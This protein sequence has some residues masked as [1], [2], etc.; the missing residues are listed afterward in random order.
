[1]MKV[2]PNSRR[3]HLYIN[4]RLLLTRKTSQPFEC[5]MVAIIIGRLLQNIG[6]TGMFLLSWTQYRPST[7]FFTYLR[8][9]MDFNMSST[10]YDT[11]T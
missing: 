11:R 7:L 8:I 5:F 3:L 10:A 1:M 2:I 4:S 6:I 9:S